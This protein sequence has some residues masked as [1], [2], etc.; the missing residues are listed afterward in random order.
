MSSTFQ[1]SNVSS[2]AG[3]GV[4]NGVGVDDG[5]EVAVGVSVGTSVGMGVSVSAGGTTGGGVIVGDAAGKIGVV[6]SDGG[7]DVVVE[8]VVAV[9]AAHTTITVNSIRRNG[10]VSVFYCSI[11]SNSTHHIT[12]CRVR[13]CRSPYS[14]ITAWES[15]LHEQ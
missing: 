15:L 8:S 13:I 10:I 6:V 2:D 14:M 9:Q 7:I 3:S 12:G 5:V 1:L 11:R 4:G